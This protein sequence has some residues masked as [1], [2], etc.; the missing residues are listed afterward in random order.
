[1][2]F[3]LTGGLVRV[4]SSNIPFLCAYP[5]APSL[6]DFLYSLL[7]FCYNVYLNSCIFFFFTANSELFVRE[8]LC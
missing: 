6:Y 1:M 4:C 7:F 5:E 8:L 3:F 2:D